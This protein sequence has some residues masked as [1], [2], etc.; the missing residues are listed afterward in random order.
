MNHDMIYEEEKVKW[1]KGVEPRERL[2]TFDC[3]EES[4]FKGLIV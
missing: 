3:V 1:N 2:I 4:M